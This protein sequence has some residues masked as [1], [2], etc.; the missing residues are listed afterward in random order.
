MNVYY[1]IRLRRKLKWLLLAILYYTCTILFE[2]AAFVY[3]LVIFY[4]REALLLHC[5]GCTSSSWQTSMDELNKQ[6]R[7]KIQDLRYFL[8]QLEIVTATVLTSYKKFSNTSSVLRRNAEIF[9]R[10]FLQG[11]NFEDVRVWRI[12]W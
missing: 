9:L 10:L 7:I 6:K 3:Y 4:P 11:L 5:S 2:A 1:F 8:P 12:S